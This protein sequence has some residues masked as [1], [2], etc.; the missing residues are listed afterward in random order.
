MLVLIKV[1]IMH[2]VK[3]TDYEIS[4]IIATIK[5]K[6]DLFSDYTDYESAVLLTVLEDIIKQCKHIKVMEV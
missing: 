3:L 4:V 6:I 1:T 5:N 2:E